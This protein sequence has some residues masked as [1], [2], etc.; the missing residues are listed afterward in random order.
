MNGRTRRGRRATLAS[1]AWGLAEAILFF[2]VP[3]IVVGATALAEPSRWWRPAMAAIAGALIGGP[4]LYLA[5]SMNPDIA[6]A[7]LATVPGIPDSMVMSAA[8]DL[9][10]QGGRAMVDAP[11]A[12]IPYKVFAAEAPAAGVALWAFLCWSIP[13]RA[14]RIIPI[15]ALT[16][17]AGRVIVALRVPIRAGLVLYACVWIAI[18][19]GYFTVVAG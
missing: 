8:S 13:A 3:D 1:F 15:A 4:A 2:L 6:S 17:L 12:G 9:V 18:Y 7:M 14:I 11:F 10:A 16:A 5:S 19:V